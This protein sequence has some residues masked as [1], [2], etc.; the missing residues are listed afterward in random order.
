MVGR[1]GLIYRVAPA[2]LRPASM[3]G[4]EGEE[5]FTPPFLSRLFWLNLRVFVT[6]RFAGGGGRSFAE[7][8]QGKLNSTRRALVT[9]NTPRNYIRL[10]ILGYINDEKGKNSAFPAIALSGS[11]ERRLLLS[12]G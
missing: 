8:Q 12:R 4:W 3:D 9:V 11:L 10:Y 6:D 1:R 5:G 2:S 7:L